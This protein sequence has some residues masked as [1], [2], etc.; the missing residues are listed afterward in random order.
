M[1]GKN[2]DPRTE[3]EIAAAY[4]SGEASIPCV[5]LEC[6]DFD[7]ELYAGLLAIRIKRPTTL[8]SCLVKRKQDG[9][10]DGS[11]HSQRTIKGSKKLPK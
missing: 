2:K 4:D 10:C 5:K 6:V 3:A 9:S 7:E 1:K 11:V 8:K